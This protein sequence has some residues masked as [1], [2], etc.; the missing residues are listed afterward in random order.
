[1]SDN[2]KPES[3]SDLINS[4]RKKHVNEM[5]KVA[6]ESVDKLFPLDIDTLRMTTNINSRQVAALVRIETIRSM[7]LPGADYLEDA[8]KAALQLNVSKSRGGRN[9]IVNIMRGFFSSGNDDDP[10]KKGL[11][12]KVTGGK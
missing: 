2:D 7:Y 10:K 9:D 8:V 11:V 5:D 3:F 1:M 4:S 6:K 12:S